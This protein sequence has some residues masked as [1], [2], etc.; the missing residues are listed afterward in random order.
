MWTSH[1]NESKK[2]P[3][4]CYFFCTQM[5]KTFLDPDEKNFSGPRWEKLFRIQK[6]KN[7]AGHRREKLFCTQLRKLF[8]HPDEKKTLEEPS[9]S[10]Y[11]QINKRK[12]HWL[13][14]THGRRNVCSWLPKENILQF[15]TMWISFV[16]E[17]VFGTDLRGIVWT[18]VDPRRRLSW[19]ELGWCD[20]WQLN[21]TEVASPSSLSPPP[22]TWTDPSGWLC[23]FQ[24]VPTTCP[25]P[26][27]EY[28]RAKGW[29]EPMLLH[30]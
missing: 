23:P 22:P 1:V 10:T 6:R 12:Q 13:K 30:R 18:P 19:S 2:Q 29:S 8:L 14:M 21:A 11:H 15:M 9:R 16:V 24:G 17:D 20:E 26:K 5:R 3:N 27:V 7:F 25:G 28:D 4:L